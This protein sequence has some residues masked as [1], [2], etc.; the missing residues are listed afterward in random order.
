MKIQYCFGLFVHIF[1][2]SRYSIAL[3]LAWILVFK[4]IF[5]MSILTI[6]SIIFPHFQSIVIMYKI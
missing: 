3:A 2:F 5:S 1:I 4:D 6:D